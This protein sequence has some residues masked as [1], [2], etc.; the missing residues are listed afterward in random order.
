ME[1]L[2]EAFSKQKNPESSDATGGGNTPTPGARG[3]H[4]PFRGGRGGA[5]VDRAAASYDFPDWSYGGTIN[6]ANTG[7]KW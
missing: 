1:K 7:K 2:T 6:I 4:A 5:A 3:G